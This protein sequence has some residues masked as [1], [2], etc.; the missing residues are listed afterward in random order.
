MN[1]SF[2]KNQLKN[3]SWSKKLFISL[4]QYRQDDIVRCSDGDVAAGRSTWG[5]ATERQGQGHL[6]IDIKS[7]VLSYI[8]IFKIKK[9]LTN[10]SKHSAPRF[11]QAIVEI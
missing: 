1:F 11:L 4:D 6:D 8:Y 2:L 3:N 10:F 7:L 5:Q 9:K